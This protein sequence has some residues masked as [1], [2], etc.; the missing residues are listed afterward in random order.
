MRTPSC[1]RFDSTS[2]KLLLRIGEYFASRGWGHHFIGIGGMDSTPEFA[3]IEARRGNRC[4]AMTTTVDGFR[5]FLVVEPEVGFPVSSIGTV[6]MEAVL[7]EDRADLESEIDG[8]I[9]VGFGRGYGV[10]W[11]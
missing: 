9:G 5:G 8:V 10:A 7:R 11:Q 6:A 2:E 3:I 4:K 1:S